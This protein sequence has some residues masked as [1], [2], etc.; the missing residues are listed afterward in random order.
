M[1]MREEQIKRIEDDHISTIQKHFLVR[2][3]EFFL[4]D[5]P[6]IGV[7]RLP[8]SASLLSLTL[9]IIWFLVHRRGQAASADAQCSRTNW[10]KAPDEICDRE[11]CR[12]SSWVFSILGLTLSF[13][14]VLSP[15]SDWREH[16][17]EIRISVSDEHLFELPDEA[18]SQR[19][20]LNAFVNFHARPWANGM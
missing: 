2:I 16:Y 13:S 20:L 17:F 4:P 3:H 18:V 12:R 8:T 9:T 7:G 10:R 6:L 19:D 11:G 5:Q 1:G 15:F 14:R